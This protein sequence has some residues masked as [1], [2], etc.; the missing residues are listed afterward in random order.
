MTPISIIS[1]SYSSNTLFILDLQSILIYNIEDIWE[2]ILL[3]H[4]MFQLNTI[5]NK[6]TIGNVIILSNT[7]Q[8]ALFTL[9]NVF[10]QFIT[11]VTFKEEIMAIGALHEN[12]IIIQESGITVYFLED[13]ELG[14]LSI[15]ER[16][17]ANS[18]GVDKLNVSDLYI[19]QGVFLLDQKLGLIKISLNPFKIEKNYEI[20]G[21]KLAGYKNLIT[22][23]GKFELNIETSIV[24]TYKFDYNC[25]FLGIDLEFIYCSID[26]KLIYMSRLIS[27]V[28][29]TV[30]K[31]IKSL[32]VIPP[33]IFIGY[34]D[35]IDINTIT[36]GPLYVEGIV[37]NKVTEYV[38]KF[39]VWDTADNN[40]SESFKLVVQ[41]TLNDV[42]IFIFSILSSIFVI[43]F[44]IIVIY[45]YC[46]RKK[47]DAVPI[48]IPVLNIPRPL[49]LNS[50]PLTERVFS[51]RIL[52]EN[53]Q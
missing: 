38:V 16:I 14:F 48:P 45:R 1:L 30:F 49:P 15:T 6:I 22:I 28:S 53:T 40:N 37:P 3:Q 29:E 47:Q 18:T 51:E 21:K 10:P 46:I 43:V 42:I 13:F 12:I 5:Y 20:Y 50:Q 41:Y 17:E 31:P 4:F 44:G 25:Q 24:S 7:N 34:R 39:T 33:I 2:P 26:D 9:D 27:I 11:T 52:I 36:L 23:D 35:Y 8:I 19:Y 32:L